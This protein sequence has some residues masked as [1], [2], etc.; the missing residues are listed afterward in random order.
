MEPMSE[1]EPPPSHTPST[2]A[3][4]LEQM[5]RR[6]MTYVYTLLSRGVRDH[7]AVSADVA[8]LI[9]LLIAKG[10]IGFTEMADRRKVA[11]ERLARAH[12]ETWDGPQL[13]MEQPAPEVRLD[14]E[15]RHAACQSACCRLYRVNLTA[16]EVRKGEVL[17]DLAMPYA[18]PR[19]PNGDC[20]YLDPKSSKCT[21]WAQRPAVCRQYSCERDTEVWSDFGNV[22][23]TE[24]VR[25][26]SRT[27]RESKNVDRSEA[28]AES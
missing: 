21:I 16:A 25:A 22:I 3:V 12:A 24:R 27:T 28:K 20:V 9:D 2:E 17:W 11:E 13:H 4:A 1:P 5:V 6:A 19:L 18:L 7:H 14:C 26:L 15:R 23:S 8:A 10:V